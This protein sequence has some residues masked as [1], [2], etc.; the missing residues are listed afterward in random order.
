MAPPSPERGREA[1]GTRASGMSS[2]M[3]QLFMLAGAL[4]AALAFVYYYIMGVLEK[5]RLLSR[6]GATH[7][8]PLRRGGRDYA[9]EDSL[10][11]DELMAHATLLFTMYY[12]R[13]PSSAL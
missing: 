9:R 1:A 4:L 11:R 7:V 6:G 10:V 2:Q 13:L 12:A 3:R 5:D 8:P